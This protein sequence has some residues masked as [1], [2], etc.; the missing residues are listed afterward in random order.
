[1][2]NVESVSISISISETSS[3]N[4]TQNAQQA[5]QNPFADPNGPF[6]NLN[7]TSQQ[8]Q[9]IAQIFSQSASGNS[10]S[11][12]QIF[13]QVN[14]ILTPQQQQTLQSDVK[15]L[16][17]NHQHQKDGSSNA[18]NSLSELDLTNSQQTE[19]GQIIQAAQTN[20]TSSSDTLNQ[21]DGVLTTT[22]QQ[23]LISLFSAD[24]S[25]GSSTQ[26]SQPYVINTSA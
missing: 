11:W 25:A 10:Q 19:I 6:A 2:S 26:S 13:S 12:N 8:Q 5:K 1:M 7:L 15:T 20:G 14:A 18:S 22:Q 3:S 4:A 23:Q 21:I 17:A 9:Q 24:T 16:R